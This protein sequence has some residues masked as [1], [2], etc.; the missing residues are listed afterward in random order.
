MWLLLAVIL[1]LQVNPPY[2][3]HG[4]VVGTYGSEKEC[5]LAHENYIKEYKPL[6]PE[7]NLGCV[8]LNNIS[9]S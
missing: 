1:N 8:A 4:E 5:A 7:M 3:H 9:E 6:P 2:I